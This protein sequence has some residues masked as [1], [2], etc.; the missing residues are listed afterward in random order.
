M[1]LL[2]ASERT[3]TSLFLFSAM[4]ALGLFALFVR[5]GAPY[6]DFKGTVYAA[7]LISSSI[8]ASF[9]FFPITMQIRP[10]ARLEE[11]FWRSA[12]FILIL[13]GAIALSALGRPIS[14]GADL[15][16]MFLFS[17][18]LF[19]STALVAIYGLFWVGIFVAEV[20]LGPLRRL[21]FAHLSRD[22]PR[23]AAIAPTL[24]SPAVDAQDAKTAA[25]DSAEEGGAS[26]PTDS[27]AQTASA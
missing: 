24:E 13:L 4:L 2:S 17:T 14:G 22:L 10:T 27:E 16:V 26:S 5:P 19:V 9:I 6:A 20:L 15:Y 12:P 11:I 1:R 3:R 23:R 18:T 7:G 8:I 25:S 21:R